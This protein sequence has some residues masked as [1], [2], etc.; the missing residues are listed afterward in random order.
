MS[1][2]PL[3]AAV[4]LSAAVVSPA[5]AAPAKSSSLVAANKKDGASYT[6]E[7]TAKGPYKKGAEGTASLVLKAKPGFHVN[8]DYPAKFKLQDPAPE[9]VTYPKKVLKKEDGKFEEMQATFGVPF[10][11]ANAGKA[12]I[13]GTFHFSVCSDKNCFLEKQDL[14][15]DVDVK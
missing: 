13:G 14:E 6:V 15:V 10:V 7:L 8:P 11:A 1:L 9:G 4:V 2:R 5:F 12:K 3:L